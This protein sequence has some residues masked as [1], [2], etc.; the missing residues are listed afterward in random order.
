MSITTTELH[1][2]AGL[3]SDGIAGFEAQVASG[4]S[5]L[6]VLWPAHFVGKRVD[7]FQRGSRIAREWLAARRGY[8]IARRKVRRRDFR[9]IGAT[10]CLRPQ[11]ADLKEEQIRCLRE[12]V[13][14]WG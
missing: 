8:A 1:E 10:Q 3:N 12:V 9:E 7:D 6:E 2:I 14:F 11:G 4:R 13:R 5:K